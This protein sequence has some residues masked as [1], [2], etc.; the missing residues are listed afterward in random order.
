MT[1]TKRKA[2]RKYSDSSC[3]EIPIVFND[4]SESETKDREKDNCRGCGDHY[5]R[6]QLIEDWIQCNIC[7]FLV[8]ENCT[9]FEDR[10]SYCDNKKKTESKDLKG[11][12]KGK[13]ST[14]HFPPADMADTSGHSGRDGQS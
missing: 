1:V 9:E 4:T 8:H 13:K 3:E 6:T 10:C 7:M 14:G 11:K 12:G 2:I 5:Y